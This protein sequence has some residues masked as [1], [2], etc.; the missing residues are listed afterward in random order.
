MTATMSVRAVSRAARMS[1]RHAAVVL[2][3]LLLAGCFY[4]RVPVFEA[5]E[6]DPLPGGPG[7]FEREVMH[8]YLKATERVELS[9]I[10]VGSGYSYL[11]VHTRITNGT[12]TLERFDAVLKKQANGRYLVQLNLGPEGGHKILIAE[13]DGKE[14]TFAAVSEPEVGNIAAS[15]GIHV[16]STPRFPFDSSLER[17]VRY[18]TTVLARNPPGSNDGPALYAPKEKALALAVALAQNES[19]SFTHKYSRPQFPR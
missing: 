8:D 6:G 12:T 13:I 10:K 17:A 4:S 15:L 3:A 11:A 19:F 5:A 9:E 18:G 16:M 1:L 7:V 2:T 14:I